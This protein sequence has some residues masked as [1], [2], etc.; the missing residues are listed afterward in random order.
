MR[1]ALDLNLLEWESWCK[2]EELPRY[3]A[4]QIY[5]WIY[6]KNCITPSSFT[7]L[8]LP[9]RERLS[10][11]FCWELLTI[12][13]RI[14]SADKSEKFLL[15]TRDNLLIE[16]VLMPYEKRVTLCVSSQ[17]GCKMGCTFCQTGKMGFKRDLSSG[18]ILAQIVLANTFLEP[19]EVTNVVFMGMGE[20]LD[21]Y[22]AV[23]KACKI[24]I[25]PKALEISKSH[26]TISTSGLV[27]QIRKIGQELPVRLAIS[28]HAANDEK[29]NKMMPVNRRFSLGELKKAL[30]VYPTSSRFGITFEYLLIEGVNDSLQDAKELVK[31]LHGLKTKVNLI[32]VN[33]F[34]GLE[35]KPSSA[36]KIQAFQSYL[37]SRS[38]P[39][40]VRY[41]RGQD[42]SGGCGQ[43]AAKRQEE[44]HQDPRAIR[45]EKRLT[46]V[47]N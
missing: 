3:V 19:R 36:E 4:A 20:P 42:I 40:P 21:N 35:M 33:H 34:P 2:E 41:S 22:E 32:P 31:F 24:M 23:I 15:R 18:E 26:V 17:I 43:L 9:V 10:A 45:R 7:N 39:A 25:D 38:I 8:S 30:L 37:S 11:S 27:P 29:R 28:L 1:N 46:K 5:Q 16:M 13:S 6:Q 12:D 47:K 14:V 44:I